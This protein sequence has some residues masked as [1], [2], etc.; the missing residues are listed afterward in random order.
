MKMFLS[1]KQ[2]CATCGKALDPVNLPLWQLS[3]MMVMNC[4]KA[5]VNLATVNCPTYHQVLHVGLS[6]PLSEPNE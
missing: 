4:H 6:F 3:F 2:V 5:G 1:G